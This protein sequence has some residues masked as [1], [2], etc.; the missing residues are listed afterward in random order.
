M[1]RR[2]WM[3]KYNVSERVIFDLFTEFTA[4]LKVQDKEE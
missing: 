3:A 1:M 4:M 2:E